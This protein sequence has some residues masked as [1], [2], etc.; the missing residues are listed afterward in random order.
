MIF[1]LFPGFFYFFRR[2]KQ[3]EYDPKTKNITRMMKTNTWFQCREPLNS[4]SDFTISEEKE[5][6]GGVELIYH[7]NLNLLIFSIVHVLKKNL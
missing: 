1:S 6:S 3:F 2:S 7:K 4:S 5:H